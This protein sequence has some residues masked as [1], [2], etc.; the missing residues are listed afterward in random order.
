ME[1]EN[2]IFNK[3]LSDEGGRFFHNQSR[4][5]VIELSNKESLKLKKNYVWVSHNQIVDL[6]KNKVIS[7]EL[8]NLFACLNIQKIK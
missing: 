4:N 6:I 3:V 8:R 2:I 1:L 7:I 5:I